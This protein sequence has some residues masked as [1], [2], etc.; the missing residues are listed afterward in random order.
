MKVVP[1]TYHQI[2]SYLTNA[3]QVDLLRSQLAAQECYQLSIREQKGEKSSDSLPL[4]D[5]IPVYQPQFAAQ[6]RAKEKDPLVV[7]PLETLALDG[8]E[9]FTYVSTLLSSKANKQLQH[10][11]L[12]N[13]YV[14]A[15]SHS[16][17]A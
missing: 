8:P 7:D 17:M 2:V 10:V 13:A 4:E 9:K 15:W 14:F 1:S 3:G 11:L 16:D 12:G 5:H 6:V